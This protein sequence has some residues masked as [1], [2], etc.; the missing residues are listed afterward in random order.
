M[1]T[2][3]KFAGRNMV[4]LR[5]IWIFVFAT[6]VLYLVSSFQFTNS[7]FDASKVFIA[8]NPLVAIWSVCATLC[9][10]VAWLLPRH[11][12]EK[13]KNKTGSTASLKKL[14]FI[15]RL[16]L[17]VSIGLLGFVSAFLIRDGNISIPFHFLCISGLLLSFPR[18]KNFALNDADLAAIK[19]DLETVYPPNPWYF[20]ALGWALI[21]L[22]AI[23]GSIYGLQIGPSLKMGQSSASVSQFGHLGWATVF[24]GTFILNQNKMRAKHETVFWI[25][26]VISAAISLPS[27][28][29]FFGLWNS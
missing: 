6:A 27:L 18:E 12:N 7:S 3:E 10:L 22:W 25:C 16:S 5:T 4:V 15:L 1:A 2:V 29:R 28:G 23:D 11:L 13:A 9:A 21:L 17:T 24:L 14:S 26:L 20:Q 8:E 19:K